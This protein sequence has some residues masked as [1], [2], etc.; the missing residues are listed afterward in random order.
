MEGWNA[1]PCCLVVSLFALPECVRAAVGTPGL[2]RT[3]QSWRTLRLHSGQLLG[4]GGCGRVLRPLTGQQQRAIEFTSSPHRHLRT[5]FYRCFDPDFA[6]ATGCSH[7]CEVMFRFAAGFKER[8]F[9]TLMQYNNESLV[10]VWLIVF[11][12][13]CGQISILVGFQH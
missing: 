12:L 10:A 4:G 9:F 5:H 1:F 8:P 7:T 3:P 6:W 2:S 11:E 13:R